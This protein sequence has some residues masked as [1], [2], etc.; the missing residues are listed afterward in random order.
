MADIERFLVDV[1]PERVNEGERRLGPKSSKASRILRRLDRNSD[2]TVT[3]PE[4]VKGVTPWDTV[5]PATSNLYESMNISTERTVTIEEPLSRRYP[6][7]RVIQA[8][9]NLVRTSRSPT[10]VNTTLTH[11]PLVTSTH[12]GGP[13][14]TSSPVISHTPLVGSNRLIS[15]PSYQNVVTNSRSP[16]Y[17]NIVNEITPSIGNYVNTLPEVTTYDRSHVQ[18]PVPTNLYNH[19]TSYYND[20][21]Y[22]SRSPTHYQNLT[23]S[24]RDFQFSP[25]RV[26]YDPSPS[27]RVVNDHTNTYVTPTTYPTYT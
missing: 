23:H 25:S 26:T 5:L 7:K 10:L 13:L 18:A 9:A 6:G 1:V 20:G 16:S 12:I 19:N 3:Y 4:F 14:L 11:S 17:R 8:D 22:R 24:N 27:R 21:V 15:R 2:S